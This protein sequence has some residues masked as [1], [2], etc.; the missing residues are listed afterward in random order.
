M[1]PAIQ[2]TKVSKRF[3]RQVALDNVSFEVPHGCVFALLGE[4]GAGKT[5]AIRIL[6][7]LEEADAGLAE[8]LGMHSRGRRLDVL[9]HVGYVPERPTLYEWMTV[10][11][12][13]WFTAGFYGGDFQ[14]H[15]DRLASDFSLPAD[16]KIKALSKGMRAKVALSLALAHRPDVLILDEPTSGLDTMV[17]RE[18]LESMVDLAAAGRTVF[19]SSHQIHEVER[20]ADIVAILREGKLVLVER[21]DE[22]KDSIRALVVTLDDGAAM[23]RVSGEILRER[24]K[25]RQWQVL[26]R[27]LGDEQLAVLRSHAAVRDVD[28]RRPALEEIFVAYMRSSGPADAD[29]AA[30]EAGSIKPASE[31][32]WP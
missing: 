15:Y 22:L 24:R 5:T 26:A 10:A 30:G 11:E 21:L 8:V 6:L 31:V 28:V 12:I 14:A 20:V 7:D 3:G 25:A 4:N 32:P 13:G 27:G 1:Q 23:P 2:L 19:L 16:R 29:S 9:R 17:R 18:F